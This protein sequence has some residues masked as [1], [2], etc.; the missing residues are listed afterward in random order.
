MLAQEVVRRHG[1][2]VRFAVQD[3]GASPLAERF[4]IDKYPAVFVDDALVA[5]PEDFYAWGGPA[6][7]KYVPWSS[8]PN[9]RKFQTDLQKMIDIRLAGGD[10]TSLVPRKS[11][12][13]IR[14][15]PTMEMVDLA[16][17][18]FTFASLQGKPVLVEFWATWCPFCIDTLSWMKSMDP[19][20]VNV[21]S[22]VVESYRKDVDALIAKLQPRGMVVDGKPDLRSAFD[23]PPA[24]PTL[25]LADKDGKIVRTFYGAPKNLHQDIEQELEILR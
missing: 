12:D 14:S 16:G 19:E 8:L 1:E 9:R 18:R 4:G 2:S 22:V 11:V 5:R 3:S 25:I 23:G 10:V 15:L 6:D 17:K 13:K 21:V 20:K 7:G 24:F